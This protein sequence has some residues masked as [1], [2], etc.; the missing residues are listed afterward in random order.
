MN[1]AVLAWAPA[2]DGTPNARLLLSGRR[3]P[4]DDPGLWT[5]DPQRRSAAQIARAK[6]LAGALPSP[7]GSW[8]AYL[9]MWNAD[10]SEDGL[11]V[12]RA[13][14]AQRRNVGLLGS[15]RWTADNRLLVIPAR[16]AAAEAH[17]VWEFLPREGGARRLTD[18]AKLPFRVANCDW[19]CSADGTQVVFVS[20]EDRGL[21]HL[22]LPAEA[23]RDTGVAPPS[24][25]APP[26][27]GAGRT[28][29]RLPFGTPPG[30]SSW[31]V[32][33]WY[34]VTTGGYRW[35]NSTYVQGQGIHFGID[36][37]APMGTPAVA[38]APGQVIAVDGDYG[39][40]PHNVVIRLDDGNVAVY[41]HLAERTR[42][43]HPGDRVEAGQVV[44]NTGDGLPPY[45]GTR[46]PHLHLEIRK[47]GRAVAT[48]PVPYFDVNWDDLPLGV[49]PGPRFEKNLDNP[50]ANQFLDDQPDIW[51]GGPIITNFARPWPP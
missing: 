6:R 15:Y 24:L 50:Q 48:N 10:P 49:W 44:G 42:H 21:W 26:P 11:W 20:A 14:G 17:A 22:A 2:P 37:A 25:Q 31:Y 9:S 39:S 18:P 46:N 47:Q 32:S 7:D 27:T 30:P 34:G 23:P 3:G 19:D 16:S 35:R 4:G 8:V 29:Y 45:D 51:F 1:G 43:V 36:F 38:V 33:Q 28:P 12:A 41:G 13:D 5:V 40:P